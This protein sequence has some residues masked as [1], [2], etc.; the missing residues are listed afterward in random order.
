VA[1]RN[2]N[3]AVSES[4]AARFGFLGALHAASVFSLKGDLAAGPWRDVLSELPRN[5]PVNRFGVWTSPDGTVGSV[6]FATVELALAPFPRHVARGASL[7]L[8]GQI[9]PRHQ[10]AQVFLTPPAGPVERHDLPGRAVDLQLRLA[11]PRI[12]RVEVMGDGAAGP[13][14]LANVPVFVDAAEPAV[15]TAV[16]GAPVEATAAA[17][18]MLSLLNRA[19]ADAHLP[20]LVWDPELAAVALA[21]SQEMVAGHFFAHV[22]PTTGTVA[23]RVRRAG[24]GLT[25]VGEN[26]SQGE[27]VQSAHEGLMDSPGHRANMLD[28]RFTHVGIGVETTRSGPPLVATL[29]FARRP[30][31]SRLTAPQVVAAINALRKERRLPHALPDPALQAAATA[32][33]DAFAKGTATT[34]DRAMEAAETTLRREDRRLGLTR[35]GGCAEWLEILELDELRELPLLASPQ[36]KKL[37]LA[38]TMARSGNPAPLVVL[39]LVDGTRC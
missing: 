28:P 24:I 36:L 16:A 18:Q 17:A 10:R 25:I 30:D 26:I 2:P 14:V 9:A 31:P 5:V 13:V 23:D 19:R 34:K 32:G 37:G 39:V 11:Q 20:A 33:I 3:S 29:V 12:Y 15:S 38:V 22:S 35:A 1:G 21:Y 6:V 8:R 7:R 4:A 27:S